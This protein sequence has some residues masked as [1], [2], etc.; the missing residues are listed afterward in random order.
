MSTNTDVN[1][2]S[3]E[4]QS[5]RYSSPPVPQRARGRPRGRPRGSRGRPRL[6]NRGGPDHA[7]IS[8]D[9][10]TPAARPREVPP[11]GRPGRKRG[12]PRLSDRGIDR[13]SYNATTPSSPPANDTPA[14]RPRRRATNKEPKY[15][16]DAFEIV[17][18]EPDIKLEEDTDEDRGVIRALAHARDEDDDDEY[19][20][21]DVDDGKYM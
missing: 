4:E 8:T 19:E 9:L 7:T 13:S 14:S 2:N 1:E 21:R 10:S 16:T 6:K 12:R 20:D 3:Q 11:R 18:I 5:A 15:S 17:G